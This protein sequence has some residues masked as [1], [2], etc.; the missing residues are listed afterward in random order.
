M[1]EGRAQIRQC[2]VELAKITEDCDQAGDLS[3]L[4]RL[5]LCH[6]E[7]GKGEGKPIRG[8]KR[9]ELLEILWRKTMEQQYYVPDIMKQAL[10]ML[11][12]EAVQSTAL[13]V[14]D[15][16][17][18]RKVTRRKQVAATNNEVGSESMIVEQQID[19]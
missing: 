10:H 15:A 18:P 6:E 7:I 17:Q 12:V 2:R 8:L 1:I 11:D 14:E 9:N 4:V 19:D 3:R 16:E 5:L 13:F